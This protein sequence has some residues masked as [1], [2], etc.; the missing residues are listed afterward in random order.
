MPLRLLKILAV[1]LRAH[2]LLALSRAGI[3]AVPRGSVKMTLSPL[4]R[5]AEAV[6][7]DTGIFEVLEFN[8]MRFGRAEISEGLHRLPNVGPQMPPPRGQGP[9]ASHKGVP[10]LGLGPRLP[11]C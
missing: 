4:R 11:V 6:P 3:G 1:R 5:A 2:Q 8:P 10:Q 7:H 9:P